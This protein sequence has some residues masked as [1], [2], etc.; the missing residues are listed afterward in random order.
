[1][2][3]YFVFTD[4]H[5]HYDVL[6]KALKTK[7][8]KASNTSHYI[9]SLGDNFDR[10]DKSVEIYNFLKKQARKGRAILLKGNHELL[11]KTALEKKRISTLDECNGLLMTI[12]EY[13]DINLLDD[14][15]DALIHMNKEGWLKFI[16]EMG[17]Y[18]RLGNYIFTHSWVPYDTLLEIAYFSNDEWH[19]AVWDD[20]PTRYGEDN[21]FKRTKLTIVNGH[22]FSWMYKIRYEEKYKKYQFLDLSEFPPE[23]YTPFRGEHI[24]AL[25]ACSE[26]SNRVN[27]LIFD[28]YDDGRVVLNSELSD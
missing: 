20:G 14:V 5:G 1:M 10:G 19:D 8:F 23:L 9:M 21:V 24:I 25:D 13:R 2:K 28:E 4:V 16:D 12:E 26:Y 15:D 22:R 11:L 6:M 27:I 7:G 3:R 17:W 18:Y